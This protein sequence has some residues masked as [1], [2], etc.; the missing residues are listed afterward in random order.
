MVCKVGPAVSNF[1]I[2]A[3]SLEEGQKTAERW[4]RKLASGDFTLTAGDKKNITS[5]ASIVAEF[6]SRGGMQSGS[7]MLRKVRV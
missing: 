4:A 1:K 3:T 6:S 5:A 7:V 2:G